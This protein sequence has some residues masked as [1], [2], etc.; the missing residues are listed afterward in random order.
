MTISVNSYL[1]D[2][3]KGNKGKQH[4]NNRRPVRREL[5]NKEEILKA[6]KKKEKLQAHMKKSHALKA[7]RRSKKK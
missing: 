6:R 4:T 2:K 7:A 3:Q 1:S 5:K